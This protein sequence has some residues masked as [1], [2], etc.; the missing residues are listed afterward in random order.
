MLRLAWLILI[1]PFF[2][3]AI[4]CIRE[5]FITKNILILM[6]DIDYKKWVYLT[7]FSLP[8]IKY[9][10]WMNP[11]RLRK[12]VKGGNYLNNTRLQ[13]YIR[14]YRK[15]RTIAMI[16]WIILMVEIISLAILDLLLKS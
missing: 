12:F 4:A 1:I 6:K 11:F 5:Y 13:D 16:C 15:N 14:L 10:L 8:G 2:V 7:S 9:L 3:F